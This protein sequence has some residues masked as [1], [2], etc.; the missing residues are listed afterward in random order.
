MSL[1]KKCMSLDNK[2]TCE[3]GKLSQC[4]S[5][6]YGVALIADLCSGSEIEFRKVDESGHYDATS[7]IL[8]EDIAK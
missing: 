4:A 1:Y 2:L 8:I 3:L 5:K 7:T 6:I